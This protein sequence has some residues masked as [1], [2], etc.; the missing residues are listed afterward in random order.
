MSRLGNSADHG[1][2]VVADRGMVQRVE[3]LRDPTIAA[4]K[5][6]LPVHAAVCSERSGQTTVVGK[7]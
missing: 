3:I 6:S 5:V 2:Y 4:C 1:H 7:M